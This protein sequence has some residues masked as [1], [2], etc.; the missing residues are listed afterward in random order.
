MA[1]E[2]YQNS[3]TLP[4][5]DATVSADQVFHL[6]SSLDTNKASGPDGISAQMLKSTANSI[7]S[8]LAELFSLS[9]ATGKFPKIWKIASVVPVPKSTAKNDPS[10]YRPIS[11]LSVVSKLLE[12]IVYSLVWDHIS[13]CSSISDWQWGFQK[14]KS[15]TAALLS[16]TNEWFKSLDRK[17][18][19]ICVFFD[20]KKA[21]DSVPHRMLMEC[22]S[23]LE[24]HPLILSWLCSYLSNR[25]QFV[26]VNGENSQSI[27]VRSGVPQGSV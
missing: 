10:N 14:H 2:T 5:D 26:R 7:A 13:D 21:F 4:C 16:T 15:T 8:P 9:L 3:H 27:A 22:L 24:F 11:L 17:E 23:Q 1:E 6:T 20:Y 18:D 25:Q 12:K 19:V